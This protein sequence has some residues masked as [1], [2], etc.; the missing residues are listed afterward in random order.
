MNRTKHSLERPETARQN[1]RLALLSVAYRECRSMLIGISY[2]YAAQSSWWRTV[3]QIPCVR[4]WVKKQIISNW[5]QFHSQHG[6]RWP[7][8]FGPNQL[9]CV[10]GPPVAYIAEM[11]MG[12]WVMDHCQWPTDPW[13]WNNCPV[14][15]NIFDPKSTLRNCSLTQLVL[16]YH[17]WRLTFNLR[18][19]ALKTESVV[20]Y[21]HAT[22]PPILC[23]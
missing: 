20:Q 12:Q 2:T 5:R 1:T 14:A 4:Q 3:A 9:T 16:Y 22:P 11:E 18:F 17:S 13:W 23:V 8:T 7:P 21:H 19:F 15:C 6:A 10:I